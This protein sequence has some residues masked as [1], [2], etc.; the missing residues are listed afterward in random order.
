MFGADTFARVYGLPS[1]ARVFDLPHE[2]QV[3]SAAFGPRKELLA[4][5]SPNRTARTW[6]LRQG[7]RTHSFDGFFGRVVDVAVSPEGQFVGTASAD[8]TARS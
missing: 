1:G 5:A 8:G 7:R 6:D 4:T 2:S 3:L